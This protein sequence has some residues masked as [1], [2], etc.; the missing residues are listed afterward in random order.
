MAEQNVP[1]T[2]QSNPTQGPVDDKERLKQ[3]YDAVADKYNAWTAPHSA[4]RLRHLAK[5]R[6]LLNNS[7]Q[8][9]QG[10]NFLELG[11]GHGVPITQELL[12]VPGA[13]VTANDLS[14]TQI[15]LARKNLTGAVGAEGMSRLS[16]VQG[17]MMGLS[18]PDASLDAV[19][20]F[21]SIIHLPR[22]EQTQI[23]GRIARWLKPGGFLVANFG[24]EEAETATMDK[25]LDEKDWMFWSSWGKE[26]TI[27]ML[28]DAGLEIQ[29]EEVLGDVVDKS[30]F[31]WIIAQ[32][33]V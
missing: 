12:S 10:Y 22:E 1:S 11:C 6:E 14:T 20:G 4:Q 32:R 15:E 16:L 33:S 13:T 27:K 7:G 8:G 26:G 9:S 21:Y 18:F 2:P 23:V 5:L 28:K 30:T 17:D 3:S 31:L 24:G 19:L 29:V 25:W